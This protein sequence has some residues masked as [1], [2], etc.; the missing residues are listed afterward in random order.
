MKKLAIL[1]ALAAACGTARPIQK[2]TEP[3]QIVWLHAKM[4]S[5]VSLTPANDTMPLPANDAQ[6]TK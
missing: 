6:V 5:T 3:K 1:L 4:V 2:P